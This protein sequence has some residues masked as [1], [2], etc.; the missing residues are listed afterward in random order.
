MRFYLHLRLMKGEGNIWRGMIFQGEME[1]D[2][3]E[4]K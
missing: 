2:K 1:H 4:Q 3:D